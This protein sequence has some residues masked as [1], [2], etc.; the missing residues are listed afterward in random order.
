MAVAPHSSFK[1]HF[2][3]LDMGT[4]SPSAIHRTNTYISGLSFWVTKTF[5]FL[6][7]GHQP[8]VPTAILGRSCG[9]GPA[10]DARAALGQ[11]ADSG[12]TGSAFDGAFSLGL[13]ARLLAR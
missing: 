7:N 4:K 9:V 11:F 12:G 1:K 2:K 10:D 5:N 6:T 3:C 13:T 8:D